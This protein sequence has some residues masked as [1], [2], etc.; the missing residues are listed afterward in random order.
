MTLA[1]TLALS[2]LV[3]SATDAER[4]VLLDFHASWC[5]PCQ[6][7]RPAIRT[8]VDSGYPV[9]SVDIDQS[10][11]LAEKY[12]VEQVPTFVVV[13]P[14]G[15]ELGRTSG[16]RPASE[17]ATL[18]NESITRLRS[19]TS[20]P[21]DDPPSQEDDPDDD[22]SSPRNPKPWKT[23]VRIKIHSPRSVGFGSGTI[24]HSTPEETV[25]L[26][27]AHIFH[28]DGAR[29]QFPPPRFPYPIRV[30]IFD[31]QLRGLKPAI[32][33][34]EEENIPGQAIDYDFDT[35]VGLIRIRP[36]RKLPYARVVPPDWTPQQGMKMTTVGCSEGHDA[37]AW[38][39]TITN[40]RFK[41]L[42]GRANYDAIECKHAPMQGRSGGGLFTL[43]GYVAGVCDFAEPRGNH[44]LYASPKS[45]HRLLD[46]NN[47]TLCYN[48]KARPR[49][50]MLAD[51]GRRPAAAPAASDRQRTKLR[52]QSD[53]IPGIRIPMPEPERVGVELAPLAQDEQ[54]PAA[55]RARAAGWQGSQ[56]STRPASEDGQVALPSRSVRRPSLD[57]EEPYPVEIEVDADAADELLPEVAPE[58]EAVAADA[59]PVEREKPRPPSGGGWRAVRRPPAE[60]ATARRVTGSSADD[61]KDRADRAR[62]P[63]CAGPARPVLVT[64]GLIPRRLNRESAVA[65]QTSRSPARLQRG[66]PERRTR[67]PSEGLRG[68]RHEP[69][70]VR[71]VP[72]P[73]DMGHDL[74][75]P[76]QILA[77]DPAWGVHR[78]R[79]PEVD[80]GVRLHQRGCD[81]LPVQAQPR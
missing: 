15:E 45:I 7:M 56:R 24:I 81:L 47:L 20:P 43:D 38:T 64:R 10:R 30:D 39:T 49:G 52:A 33:H 42:V 71:S 65:G 32:V 78:R 34:P 51:N 19:R 76:P 75:T 62:V 66:K 9:Q 11:R 18:Y 6:Q 12:R 68:S 25:I 41:G 59:T 3:L 35:D 50:E 54:R 16:A 8:L 79:G 28:I 37:T 4:P 77:V 60:T 73:H 46:R 31:G 2:L 13:G 44:G 70:V 67:P 23:V 63:H 61:P 17:L 22:A 80:P 72:E 5:G 53:S 55:S 57:A 1:T 40:P 21:R 58:S 27:C 26:T 29:Q 48:P 74:R 36:G 69:E 14:N